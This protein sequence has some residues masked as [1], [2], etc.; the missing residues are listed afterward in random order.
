MVYDW[1]LVRAWEKNRATGSGRSD[2]GLSDRQRRERAEA[3]LAEME[4]DKAAGV[5]IVAEDARKVWG[6]QCANMRARLLSLPATA[7]TRIEDG[8]T[9]AVREETLRSLVAEALA[10]LSGVTEAVDA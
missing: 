3:D 4:R 7:A 8:M 5:L 9:V 10:E 6:E 2:S 1:S